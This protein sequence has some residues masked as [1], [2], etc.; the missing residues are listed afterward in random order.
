[1]FTTNMYMLHMSTI[2]WGWVK[3]VVQIDGGKLNRLKSCLIFIASRRSDL[4][5]SATILCNL[6][7]G[8]RSI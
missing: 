2:V 6:E 3:N 1:M 4:A 8:V 7:M 5:Y